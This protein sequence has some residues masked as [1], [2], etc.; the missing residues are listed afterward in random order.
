[1]H[2]GSISAR[3]VC[4]VF[5]LLALTAPAQSQPAARFA[6]ELAAF[7][8]SDETT[9]AH[10]PALF[11]GSSSIRLWRTLADDMAPVSTL[12]RG[13]GGA[14]IGEINANFDLL[15]ARSRPWAIFFYAGENDIS[16]GAAPAQV[17]ADFTRFL[18]L[19][20]AALGDT[21]VYFISLKPSPLRI[22]QLAAQRDVNAAIRRLARSRRDLAY[23]DVASAMLDRGQPRDVYVEDGLHMSPGGYAIWTRILRPLVLHQT[24]RRRA[25]CSAD[26]SLQQAPQS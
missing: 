5:A 2:R 25:P 10:C 19:K 22:G 24:A 3:F 4:A 15:V 26:D 12:N 20:D 6:A 14:T 21:P 11:V 9:P 8:R 1:V 17:I 18:E 23:V 13:F 7:A 16:E